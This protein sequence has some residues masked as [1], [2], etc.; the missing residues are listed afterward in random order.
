M[1]KGSQWVVP[2][3]SP[4][5]RRM[6]YFYSG[7][8]VSV[9]GIDVLPLHSIELLADEKVIVD[10]GDS[11]CFLLLLQ[12]QP[13]NEP[14]AQY[15]PFVMNTQAEIQQAI[16]DFR[17]TQFGGWP[18]PSNDHVHPKN[19]GRFAKYADGSNDNP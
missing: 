12:G 17:R 16:F 4:G 13:I 18:W 2:P 8:S 11:D 15:G 19:I 10:G 3:A 1:Q 7:S 9:A 6:L 5:V 14:V